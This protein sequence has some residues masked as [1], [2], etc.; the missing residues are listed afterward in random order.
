MTIALRR[1]ATGVFSAI[2]GRGHGAGTVTVWIDEHLRI[3]KQ[4]SSGLSS[5][6]TL[7]LMNEFEQAEPVSRHERDKAE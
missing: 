5:D 7:F 3:P 1:P 4:P 6:A 2:S